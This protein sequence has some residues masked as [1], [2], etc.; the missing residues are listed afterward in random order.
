MISRKLL[1]N[2]KHIVEG[3]SGTTFEWRG[4][5]GRL[6]AEKNDGTAPDEI[7]GDIEQDVAESLACLL[8]AVPD[9]LEERELA[10]KEIERLR[11]EIRRMQRTVYGL[12]E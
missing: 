4:D 3:F 6:V 5:L 7:G 1:I 11:E 10:T 2:L 9:L 8:N 12:L